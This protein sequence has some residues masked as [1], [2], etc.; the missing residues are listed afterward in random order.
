[1][2]IIWVIRRLTT[3]PHL[4]PGWQFATTAERT[5]MLAQGCASA[6]YDDERRRPH[7]ERLAP[8]VPV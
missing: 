2:H 8:K 3:L 5:T 1:M 4:N 7:I 6:G